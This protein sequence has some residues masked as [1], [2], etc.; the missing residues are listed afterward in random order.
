MKRP[1]R[2]GPREV[3]V[4]MLLGAAA[5]LAI[6]AAVAD[7]HSEARFRGTGNVTPVARL[8]EAGRT[9]PAPDG[10]GEPLANLTGPA[11]VFS[12]QNRLAPNVQ[13]QNIWQG[14]RT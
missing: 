9:R 1:A 7:D 3:R 8:G 6:A 11:D 12:V 5:L 10:W 2:N 4:A 13:T 14:P